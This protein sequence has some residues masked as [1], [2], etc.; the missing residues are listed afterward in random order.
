MLAAM[1]AYVLSVDEEIRP[2]GKPDGQ[3]VPAAAE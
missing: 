2:G 1:A 3:R